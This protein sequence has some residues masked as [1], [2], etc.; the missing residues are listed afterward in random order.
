MLQDFVKSNIAVLFE[1]FTKEDKPKAAFEL[2]L[3]SLGIT[4]QVFSPFYLGT[5]GGKSSKADYEKAPV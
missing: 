4:N 3:H 2:A 5:V 1:Q